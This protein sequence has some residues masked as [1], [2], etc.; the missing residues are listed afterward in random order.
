MQLTDENFE[1]EILNSSKPV[2]VDFFATWCGPCSVLQPILEKISEDLEGKFILAKANIDEVPV[3][4]Q[5][6]GINVIPTIILFKNGKNVSGFSGLRPEGIIKEWLENMLA[7]DSEKLI[8]EYE[9]YAKSRGFKLN[10]DK[11]ITARIIKGLLGNEKKHG[12]RFCPCRRV[13]GNEEEDLKNVCPCA[14][15]L[16]EIEKNGHCLC[17]LFVNQRE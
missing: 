6:L 7:E 3:T 5:K 8:K 4:S 13:T 10:P 11:E 17:Q 12:K 14:Y 1:K 9:G 2:L 15:H 16:E